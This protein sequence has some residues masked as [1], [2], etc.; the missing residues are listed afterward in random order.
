MTSKEVRIPLSTLDSIL[1]QLSQRPDIERAQAKQLQIHKLI[2]YIFKIVRKVNKNDT[3]EIQKIRK[4]MDVLVKHVRF[5]SKLSNTDYPQFDLH[6]LST[7]K[8]LD[9]WVKENVKKNVKNNLMFIL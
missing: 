2:L 8:Q 3:K 7:I 9:K 6:I 5:Y 4:Q 1:L